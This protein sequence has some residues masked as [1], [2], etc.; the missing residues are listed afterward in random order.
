MKKNITICLLC[1][2]G[3]WIVFLA[4]QNKT[5]YFN[6]LGK[7]SSNYYFM[8]D[9]NR[10]KEKKTFEKI[11]DE[12]ML[13]WDGEHFFAINEKGYSANEEYRF[14]FFP[15]FPFIWKLTTLSPSNVIFLNFF[16]F[17]CGLLILAYLFKQKWKNVLVILSLPMFVVFLIPYTE[18]TFF[19]MFSIAVLGYMKDK[20]WLYFI[21]MALASLSRNTILF[22]FPAIICVE[23]LFFIKERNLRQSLIRTSLGSLPVLIG[24]AILSLIQYFSGS[25]SIFKF[26]ES[27]KY[28]GHKFSFPNFMNLHDWSYE[29]FVINVPTLIMIG[30][31]LSIFLLYITLRQL[32]TI[33]KDIPF[34]SF[35]SEN[36]L[37]YL[38][39][40]II[41][42][43]M[44]AFASI[45]LF[46]GGGLFGLSRF[47]LCSPYFVLLLFL[48]QEKLLSITSYKRVIT[49]LL[50]A[51]YSFTILIL[52]NYLA[53][54]GF[55]YL[56]FFIFVSTMALY[57]F[58]DTKQKLIYKV[59]LIGT[60][61]LNI[62]WTTYLFNMFLCN[63]WLYT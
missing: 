32:N 48:N 20:Y 13:H 5:V 11:A 35:S 38:N 6:T 4:M 10:G 60:G 31:P 36:K 25:G 18:A 8:E 2:I 55:H 43:S 17:A 59:F 22:V 42:C 16:M 54:F 9:G 40:V 14:A 1:F 27:Q 21:A 44:A 51:L 46:R 24:T 39:L 50:L 56:G 26:L 45:V 49:F 62:L 34:L 53:Y 61:I 47:L 58:K 7:I 63:G 30:I 3:F 52:C 57:L 12:N 29:S 15:L 37:D 23:I 19:L 41:F 33:K 28:W